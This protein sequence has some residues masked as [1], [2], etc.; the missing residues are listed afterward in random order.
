M[1]LIYI[2][3]FIKLNWEERNVVEDGH[4]GSGCQ[5]NLNFLITLQASFNLGNVLDSL[6]FLK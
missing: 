5:K 4:I 2:T 3:I 1:P 6:V